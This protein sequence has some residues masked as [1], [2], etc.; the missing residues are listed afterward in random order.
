MLSAIITGLSAIVPEIIG[1]ISGDDAEEKAKQVA[2]IATAITGE[3]DPQTAVD[4]IKQDP[5]QARKFKEAV[6]GF[7]L[8]MEQETTK[9]LSQINQTMRAGYRESGWKSGWRPFFGYIFAS[10]FGMMIFGFIG[11]FFYF[12]TKS[13]DQAIKLVGVAPQFVAAFTPM[14]GMGLAVLGIAIK[15]RSDDKALSGGI[16][17]GPQKSSLLGRVKKLFNK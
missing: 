5:E 8:K 12:A 17:S 10:A 16:S 6:M 14:F 2:D 4:I 7:R 11:L 9:Q 3:S 1:M 15:K 13:L